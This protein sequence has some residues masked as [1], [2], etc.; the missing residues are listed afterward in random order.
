[1]K[2]V[3]TSKWGGAI[4][5]PFGSYPVGLSIF[6]SDIDVS[7][8]GM[9]VDD[10]NSNQRRLSIECNRNTRV[11]DDISD[12]VI[13]RIM[14]IDLTDETNQCA[15]SLGPALAGNASSR[16]KGSS[17]S[18]SSSSSDGLKGGKQP[19]FVDIEE[20]GDE[21]D[22]VSWSLDTFTPAQIASIQTVPGEGV[23][24]A[25]L[26][27][28]K[29]SSSGVNNPTQSL[30]ISAPSVETQGVLE[31]QNSGSK[32]PASVSAGDVDADTGALSCTVSDGALSWK[33]ETGLKVDPALRS[34]STMLKPGRDNEDSGEWNDTDGPPGGHVSDSDYDSANDKYYDPNS[35]DFNP[36][37]MYNDMYDSDLETEV[38]HYA[39]CIGY[40]ENK[41]FASFKKRAAAKAA[42]AAAVA[43]AVIV[44]GTE[45]HLS[46]LECPA[47]DAPVT[48]KSDVTVSRTVDAEESRALHRSSAPSYITSKSIKM[49]DLD[50]HSGV[51]EGTLG[52]DAFDDFDDRPDDYDD[53]IDSDGSEGSSH[54]SEEEYEDDEG[55][56]LREEEDLFCEENK[57]QSIGRG[58]NS[59]CNS[60][61][62]KASS[63][64]DMELLS[65]SSSLSARKVTVTGNN[66]ILTFNA[67][68]DTHIF[69]R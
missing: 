13:Q 6:L 35:K 25:H 28:E 33:Q 21:E 9:G 61:K 36:T 1:L 55:F 47:V 59:N 60:K 2:D 7:I 27:Q 67:I 58:N 42:A 12:R 4:M 22:E 44:V 31:V 18:S 34:D 20:S 38:E 30:S 69:L 41:G 64:L 37:G 51:E 8:L 32:I 24:T 17:S 56:I 54:C 14:P 23:G 3:I 19:E 49:S 10:D 57:V 66:R 16:S 48:S 52:Q 68:F 53:E 29:D 26:K 62:R 40:T 11:G 63:S 5:Q 46:T 15:S 45:T 50:G 65:S 43:A 39:R